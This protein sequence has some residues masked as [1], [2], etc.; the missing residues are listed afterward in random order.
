MPVPEE[1]YLAFLDLHSFPRRLR[2]LLARK[3]RALRAEQKK[4]ARLIR[5]HS[6]KTKGHLQTFSLKFKAFRQVKLP[7]RAE[8]AEKE[9]GNPAYAA[10]TLEKMA[11]DGL[12][13]GPA[14][15]VWDSAMVEE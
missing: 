3:A 9:K 5:K 8:F 14:D 7:T 13:A 11:Q 1:A 4:I 2:A 10:T 6:E 15:A 12:G